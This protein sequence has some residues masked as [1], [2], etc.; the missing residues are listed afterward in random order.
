MKYFPRNLAMPIQDVMA[1]PREYIIPENLKA[2]EYLWDMNIMTKQT[3]DY[4]NEDSWIAIGM[5]SKENEDI[6]NEMRNNKIFRDPRTPGILTQYGNGFRI[7]IKPGTKDTFETFL[8]LFNQFQVQDVQRDGYMTIDEFYA[9]YTDCWK[10]IHNPYIDLEPKFE[11]YE[12]LY[13]Y[14][15]ARRDFQKNKYPTTPK[16]RV[17]DETKATK[18]LEEYLKEAGFLDC[19]DAE[20]KKIFLNKRLYE[21]HMKYKANNPNQRKKR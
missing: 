17:F 19:Y 14:R 7:P 13:T 21:G 1:N 8:Q 10:V 12:N 15:E 3:N 5:L 4:E 6:Y 20:E 16:I 9:N 11:D 2:I 18:S